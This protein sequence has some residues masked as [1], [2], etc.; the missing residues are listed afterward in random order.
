GVAATAFAGGA[1][2]VFISARTRDARRAASFT[3]LTVTA[4]AYLPFVT[5]MLLPRLLPRVSPWFTPLA[6]RLIE[7]GPVG[8]VLH[9][10]GVVR[11]GTL[12]ETVVRMIVWETAVG[13]ALLAWTA[14]RF[15]ATCRAV[16]D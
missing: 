2:G 16:D 1:L 11:R 8:L 15:R 6:A 5:V 7:T 3:L 14:W 4:W 9:I 10:G 12:V 13:A